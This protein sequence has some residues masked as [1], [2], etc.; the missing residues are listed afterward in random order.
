MIR[1]TGMKMMK[2]QA[3][4]EL[5]LMVTGTV[6]QCGMNRHHRRQSDAIITERNPSVRLVGR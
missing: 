4:N 2:W 3:A 6:V 5:R 1:T